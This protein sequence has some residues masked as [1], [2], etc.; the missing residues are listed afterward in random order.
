[1]QYCV[2]LWPG[3]GAEKLLSSAGFIRRV[4]PETVRI[5][6]VRGDV[7]PDSSRGQVRRG[8]DD[9]LFIGRADE[10]DGDG[11]V[12]VV[13]DAE[14]GRGNGREAQDERI[15][16]GVDAI[17]IVELDRQRI[18]I[19][20]SAG[21]QVPNGMVVEDRVADEEAF[22]IGHEGRT[23][24]VP[25]L[26]TGIFGEQNEAKI[27][28]GGE[29][30]KIIEWVVE[31]YGMNAK[32]TGRVARYARKWG[33]TEGQ[34]RFKIKLHLEKSLTIA[35]DIDHG[36][37]VTKGPWSHQDAKQQSG[38]NSRPIQHLFLRRSWDWERYVEQG[39]M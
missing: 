3:H 33:T 31:E 24:V 11:V 1:M 17:G 28:G 5:G 19:A 27:G 14:L 32:R 26:H 37:T 29:L 30:E 9:V 25:D 38:D 22:A 8:L 12:A 20:G 23:V 21:D 6:G 13:L 4:G 18:R 34:R 16:V 2:L 39:R 7:A 36:F 35:A 10:A 15:A